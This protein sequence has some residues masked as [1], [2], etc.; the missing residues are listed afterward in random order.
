MIGSPAEWPSTLSIFDGLDLC[1]GTGTAVRVLGDHG[2][3]MSGLDRSKEMLTVAGKKL[4]DRR[5]QLYHQELPRFEIRVKGSGA[6]VRL[7]RFDLITCYFDSLNYLLTERRLRAAFRAVYRHLKPGGWFIFDMNTPHKL[8]SALMKR[9]PYT[10]VSDEA[11]WIFRQKAPG[12]NE[13]VDFLLTFFIRTEHHW[14]RY[15]EIH[16]ERGYSNTSIRAMLHDARLQVRGFYRCFSFE[17]PV[18]T[19]NRI[20]VAARRPA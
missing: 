13:V 20:C 11:A 3:T 9:Q 15:D 14:R 4:R 7:Q 5:V 8:K 17:K 19:T 16:R 6:R 2:L 1:C 12:Q 18:R 10:G